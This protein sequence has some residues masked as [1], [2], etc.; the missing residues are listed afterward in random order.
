MLSLQWRVN[1]PHCLLDPG[2]ICEHFSPRKDFLSH[3]SSPPAPVIHPSRISLSTF[4]GSFPEA[5][6]VVIL[7]TLKFLVLN[8]VL[9]ERTAFHSH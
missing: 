9:M 4:T 7:C 3:V 5:T 2:F 8:R 6:P 1:F